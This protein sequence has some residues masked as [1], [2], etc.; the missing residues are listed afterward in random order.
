MHSDLQALLDDIWK[1]SSNGTQSLTYRQIYAGYEDPSD[2]HE[3]V[4][5][6]VP[7]LDLAHSAPVKSRE[8]NESVDLADD[9]LDFGG[10]PTGQGYLW[11]GTRY[12][13]PDAATERVV[14]HAN[15][16]PR[17]IRLMRLILGE[18]LSN[19]PRYSGVN[20]AKVATLPCFA[21]GRNDTIIVYTHTHNGT[22][23]IIY[24]LNR[25]IAEG[26]VSAND[27]LGSLPYLI[28]EEFTGIGWASEPPNGVQVLESYPA[29]LSFG[30][31]L[32]QVLQI[33]LAIYADRDN[34][35]Q[36]RRTFDHVMA[37]VL[38]HA[39]FDLESPHQIVTP[40]TE[41]LQS[42]PWTD[43][44]RWKNSKLYLKMSK[45]HGFRPFRSA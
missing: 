17:V 8:L 42:V 41:F 33:G 7:K 40:R 29:K 45:D 36:S 30:K 44:K 5:A 31:Y 26:E 28:K 15:P 4:E 2:S 18:I 19:N 12:Y 32:S 37:D 13:Q 43:D 10:E 23:A 38:T 25:W 20:S 22:L 24:R 27:F 1:K 35:A 34:N 6:L 9:P 3:V 14:I 21:S 16:Y 39:G 11:F